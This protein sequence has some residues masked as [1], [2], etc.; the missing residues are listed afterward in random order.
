MGLHL[1]L[2]EMGTSLERWVF[3]TEPYSFYA[4]LAH[5][6]QASTGTVAMSEIP[7]RQAVLLALGCSGLIC[8]SESSSSPCSLQAVRRR[9]QGPG[10]IA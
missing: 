10:E 8:S 4:S 9:V 7:P 6:L 3:L 2:M 1:A 5:P